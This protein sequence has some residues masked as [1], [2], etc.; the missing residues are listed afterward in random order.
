MYPFT[1]SFW[2]SN[3]GQEQLHA[4]QQWSNILFNTNFSVNFLLYCVSGK[5][6]RKS[7]RSTLI[8][9]CKRKRNAPVSFHITGGVR[10]GIYETVFTRADS[11]E[12]SCSS[13]SLK[14]K[15]RLLRKDEN[16]L[17]PQTEAITFV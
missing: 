10:S 4:A 11:D 17:N 1:Q 5:S 15:R 6:F 7:L 12:I 3:G 13:N 9:K 8:D 14:R 2:G 16:S